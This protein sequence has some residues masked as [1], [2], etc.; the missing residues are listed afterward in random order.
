M[1]VRPRVATPLAMLLL[2]LIGPVVYVSPTSLAAVVPLAGLALLAA[3]PRDQLLADWLTPAWVLG[4]VA[5][6]ALVTAPTALDAGWAWQRS[7]RLIAELLAAS[8]LIATLPRFGEPGLRAIALGFGVGAAFA[9]LDLALAGALSGWARS[10]PDPHSIRISYSRGAVAH[11]LML[12]PLG[13]MMA[14]RGAWGVALALALPGLGAVAVLTSLSAQV[15]ILA[16][17]VVLVLVLAVP[18]TVWVVAAM[19]LVAL[20]LAPQ[21]PYDPSGPLGCAVAASKPSA[22]HRLHIWDFVATRVGE[23]PWLG[24]GIEASRSLPGGKA[25]IDLKTCGPQAEVIARGEQVPLHPHNAALQVWLEL[26]A[27][28]V[29]AVAIALVLAGRRVV[30]LVV[31][32]RWAGAAGAALA[33]SALSAALISYGLW[34]N[35]WLMILALVAA[36]HAT[37][38]RPSL[39]RQSAAS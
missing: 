9:L 26:G 37:I 33:A 12:V 34:Q 1:T 30:A 16:A 31:R 39:T 27:V 8:L 35:W 38:A 7:A 5:A 19:P 3:C 6:A 36:V 18:A 13:V 22:L 14:R 15:A 21:I 2:G 4:L 25:V 10:H 28:G 11:A 32:D 23:R 17:A 29:I 24:H 20:A